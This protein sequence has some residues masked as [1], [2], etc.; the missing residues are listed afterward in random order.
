M[1][2]QNERLSADLGQTLI[3]LMQHEHEVKSKSGTVERKTRT[4]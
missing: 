3:M 4:Y 2:M 1:E